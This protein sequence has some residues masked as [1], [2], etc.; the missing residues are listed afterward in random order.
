[1][2]IKFGNISLV[3][4][5][6]ISHGLKINTSNRLS[7]FIL[8]FFFFVFFFSNTALTLKKVWKMIR[9][10]KNHLHF[11]PPIWQ[12]TAIGFKLTAKSLIV[13]DKVSLKN[14]I[15]L[16]IMNN[17]QTFAKRTNQ[18]SGHLV[19][20]GVNLFSGTKS[21]SEPGT[22]IRIKQTIYYFSS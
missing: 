3:K 12:W 7:C 1:M 18:D 20:T 22:R 19:E 6:T 11:Y 21:V 9:S 2:Y 14:K 4:H 15:I 13:G 17:P 10:Y 8:G 16:Y 5:T